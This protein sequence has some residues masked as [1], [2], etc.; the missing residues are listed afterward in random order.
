MKKIILGLILLFCYQF[1]HAQFGKLGGK[2][3]GIGSGGGGSKASSTGSTGSDTAGIG[4][5]SRREYDAKDSNTIRYR[6]LDSSRS[7]TFARPPLND[8]Y[9]YFPVPETQ[10]YLGNTGNAGYSIIYSPAMKI[11][12]DAGFHAFD[13]YRY[14]L[15][16]TRFF[17][18]DK[19]VTQLNYEL[20]SGK[21]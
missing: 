16:D 3:G 7:N 21:E 19:P 17:K 5:E 12:W 9:K 11:G 20:A 14:S 10:Q 6:Y 4:F 13:A 1:S 15:E 18:T 2:L 8:F